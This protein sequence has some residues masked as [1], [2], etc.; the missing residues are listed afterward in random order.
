MTPRP[1]AQILEDLQVPR[2]QWNSVRN[3]AMRTPDLIALR[4]KIVVR[5][6]EEVVANRVDP[7][8]WPE[9]ARIM[10]YASHVG[11]MNAYRQSLGLTEPPEKP[12]RPVPSLVPEVPKSEA[13]RQDDE[14]TVLYGLRG[15]TEQEDLGGCGFD[16]MAW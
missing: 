12:K 5:L 13:D 3:H 6:R 7:R 2:R 14:A 15:L 1:L 10:G 8:S 4:W 9:I 11:A 16:P